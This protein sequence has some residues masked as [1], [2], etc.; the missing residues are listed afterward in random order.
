MRKDPNAM[1]SEC[2]ALCN[3]MNRFPNIETYESCCGHG[4]TPYHI[5]FSTKRLRAL[6]R[7]LYWFNGCHTGCYGWHVEVKTDCG[8]SPATFMLEGPTGKVAYAESEHIANCMNC[9]LD[10]AWP[11]KAPIEMLVEVL[12]EHGCR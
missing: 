4:N 6:P 3:A 2:I 1:D 7:L 11:D 5:W 12:E 10:D 8:M 9:Y